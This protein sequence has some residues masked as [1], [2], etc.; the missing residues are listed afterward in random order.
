MQTAAVG[1]LLGRKAKG[2]CTQLGF[3]G[4][5]RICCYLIKLDT[6]DRVVSGECGVRSGWVVSGSIWRW[7][8]QPLPTTTISISSLENLHPSLCHICV[9]VNELPSLFRFA[10]VFVAN[11][12]SSLQS[13]EYGVL[14][15]ESKARTVCERHT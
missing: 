10:F 3:L 14:S 12:R 5:P 6:A 9:T 15:P 13:T 2:L 7:V 11:Q 4:F 1:Q 8:L